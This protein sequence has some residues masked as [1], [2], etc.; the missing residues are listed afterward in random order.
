MKQG[1]VIGWEAK[2]RH[3]DLVVETRDADQMAA[4][5]RKLTEAFGEEAW[6]APVKKKLLT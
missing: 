4:V 5:S 2:Q 3:V 1:A 6:L